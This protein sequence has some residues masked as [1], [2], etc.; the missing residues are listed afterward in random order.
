MQQ[1]LQQHMQ[2]QQDT[3]SIPGLESDPEPA[4][5]YTLA[6]AKVLAMIMC[7]FNERMVK[8]NKIVHGT[9]HVVTYSLKKA[10]QNPQGNETIA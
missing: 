4:M 7:Q 8:T 1:Q 2:Q 9:Q 3:S 10:I 5:E 6:E